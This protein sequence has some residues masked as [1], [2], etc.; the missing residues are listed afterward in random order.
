MTTPTTVPKAGY[1]GDVYFGTT[2]VAAATWTHAGGERQMQAVDELGDELILDVPLQIRGGVITITGHYK[3]D[4]D[5]GQQLAATRF[6]SGAQITDLKLYTDNVGATKTYLTPASGSYATVTNCRNVGDDK[7]GI[8]TL[9]ISL[10]MSGVLEQVG[11]TA[12]VQ[13]ETIGVHDVTNTT[14]EFVGNL[15]SRGG[16]AGDIECY[17]IFG[18]T[19]GTL[20][21][22]TYASEDTFATPDKG[23]F[24]HK[25]TTILVADTTY[26]Y[27][28]VALYDTDKYAYGKIKSFTTTNV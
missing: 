26:Y 24:G 12:V 10:L 22:T 18:T 15:V 8:G 1:K 27:R 19:E 7:S 4:S 11:D 17:F 20:D 21:Q 23:L 25:Q 6:A 5:T 14:V 16:Q 28:S 9:S 3:L 2:K 13:L